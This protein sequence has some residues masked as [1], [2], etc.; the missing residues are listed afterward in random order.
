MESDTGLTT[1]AFIHVECRVMQREYK[2][3]DIVRVGIVNSLH[4]G[5]K[6]FNYNI[7]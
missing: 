1:T 7:I 6:D 5:F 4:L 3:V 2:R